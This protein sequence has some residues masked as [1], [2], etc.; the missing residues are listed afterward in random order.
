[1]NQVISVLHIPPVL[2]AHL[3]KRCGNLAK[4]AH[5]YR[6]HQF[7]KHIPAGK[8]HPLEFYQGRRRLLP[9]FGLKGVEAF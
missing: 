8:R 5:L 9:M 4:A 3:V 2:A 1:M 6:L 7:G